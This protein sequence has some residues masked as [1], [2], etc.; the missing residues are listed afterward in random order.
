MR[1]GI[2][3]GLLAAT[4]LVALGGCRT[5]DGAPAGTAP[6]PAVRVTTAVLQPQ[7]W[8]DTIEALGTA[9]AN[10]SV[11]LTAKITETVRKVNFNDGQDVAAG[12]VLVELTSG[13]QVAALAEAQA[14][15]RDATRQFERQQDLVRQGTVSRA[16]FDTAQATRDS[17]SARVNALRAQLADRVV[18]APFAGVLGLRQ[19]S[20]G[21]LV[22]PGDII[23]TLDDISVI[24]LDFSLPEV[25]LAAVA[26]GQSVV[27]RS[28]A[29]P[30]RS[31]EG[32]VVSLDSRIDP[33]TRAFQVR[34]T[35]PN[36]DRALR[37]GMLLTVGILRPQREVLVVPE[38]ALVQVG[39]EASVFRVGADQRVAQVKVVPGA[40]RRG[41]VE[42]REGLATGDRIVVDGTVKL[43]DGVQVAEAAA[44]AGAEPG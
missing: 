12:D 8:T 17:N 11:T 40:R 1:P 16:V 19:V 41:T 20:P 6:P 22:R 2:V 3:L 13:Q 21:A 4:A 10:E 5:G 29:F 37:G 30:G 36:P 43:R 26:A 32:T 33:V 23:T 35:I 42:I 25:H 28:P 44:T 9:K 34:A 39:T 24:K 31:F 14:T 18:T 7:A 15:S 38:I 27:A